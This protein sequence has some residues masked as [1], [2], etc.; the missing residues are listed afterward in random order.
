MATVR[1]LG[2]DGPGELLI[3]ALKDEDP[4]IRYV[5]IGYLRRAGL[6]NETT[7]RHLLEVFKDEKAWIRKETLEILRRLSTEFRPFVYKG[8]EDEDPRIRAGAAYVLARYPPRGMDQ[9]PPLPPGEQKII[10]KLVT[11][12]MRD[13]NLEVRKAAYYCLFSYD[14]DDEDAQPIVSTLEEAVP[15]SDKDAR[16]LADRLLRLTKL[17]YRPSR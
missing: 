7:V 5:A 13:E 10:A 8:V 6:S 9:P 17:K 11:P 14:F 15:E 1:R 2:K 4:D 12:L 16:D 3:E